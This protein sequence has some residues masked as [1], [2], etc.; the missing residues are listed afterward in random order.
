GVPEHTAPRK[1]WLGGFEAPL[2]EILA[3]SLVQTVTIPA[4]TTQ[5]VISGV[6]DGRNHEAPSPTS[7]DTPEPFVARTDG[8]M[9]ATVLALSNAT[10]KA[11]WTAFAYTF[12][13]NL[14]GKTVRV[15]LS[16]TNDEL[17]PTS[18]YFDSLALTATQG[19]AQ[20]L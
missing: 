9:F 7:Y 12:T 18:F 2:G 8:S 5:L 14:S 19:C 13:Q 1:A 3:D 11:G 10:P 17:D 20:A 15:R 4:N 6:Y 16:S